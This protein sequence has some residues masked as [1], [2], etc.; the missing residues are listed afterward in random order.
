MRS[1]AVF[2]AA[3]VGWCWGCSAGLAGGQ[4][5]AAPPGGTVT[6]HVICGDTQRPARF[7]RVELLSV[8]PIG[9]TTPKVDGSDPAAVQ[10]AVKARMDAM[11]TVTYVQTET[12]FDG[13][14]VA[15]SVPSGDYY[16]MAAVAGYME[17]RELM[18]AAYDAGE[19]VT[20]GISGVPMVHV[21]AERTASADVTVSRGAA[22]EGRVLWD[23]GGAVN[24]AVVT[25]ESTAKEATDL[26]AQFGMMG[27]SA[28]G[29]GITRISDDLGHYRISG[30]AP[31]EYV[32][33][34]SLQTQMRMSMDHGRI[35]L[36]GMGG[37]MPL[38]VYA[39]S[40]FH[41]SG[42]KPVTL[43]AGEEHGD[44]DITFNLS[45]TH[46]VSGRVASAEDHHP[47]NF[48]NVL[49]TDVND[50]SFGRMAPVDAD[51]SFSV[52]FV[53]PGTY[54]MEVSGSDTVIEMGEKGA[55]ITQNHI[56][57]NYKSVSQQVM[58][59]DDDVTGQNFELT[60]SKGGAGR[61]TDQMIDE[62]SGGIGGTVITTSH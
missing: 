10:A 7:A 16:V 52:T 1:R 59:P 47:L 15:E 48:G 33:R 56:V 3:V 26:P 40:A 20:K 25:V 50:K 42:A 44:E 4:T 6:G 55:R 53:P 58:V 37:S 51:G 24:G 43:N 31:G 9:T 8:P 11:N 18:A 19:D 60:P 62:D 32:V 54:T 30:L 28:A 39:P 22:I 17:P 57:R 14:F 29:A 27:V 61:V 41:K 35:N 21:S 2:V 23:D 5:A 49:L 38:V 12:G 34:A 45:G 46:A 13:S 36:N